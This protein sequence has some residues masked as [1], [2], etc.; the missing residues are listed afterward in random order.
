MTDLNPIQQRIFELDEEARDYRST[1]LVHRLGGV[2]MD[3]VGA[4][5]GLVTVN[6]IVNYSHGSPMVFVAAGGIAV[7]TG[8]LGMARSYNNRADVYEKESLA[9]QRIYGYYR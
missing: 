1:A 8:L 2:I 3:G 7:G 9:Q 4:M 5:A 6:E